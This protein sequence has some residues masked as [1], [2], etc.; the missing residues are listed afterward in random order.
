MDVKQLESFVCVAR[1]GSMTSAA[2]TLYLSAPAL[3]QH[4]NQ[5]EKEAK[6]SLFQR[7]PRGMK[8]TPAGE[9]FYE[10]AL[11]VLELTNSML[12]RCR[13][14]EKSAAQTVRIGS[15]KGLVPDFFPVIQRAVRKY[16]PDIQVEHVEDHF[17][18]LRRMLL[19]GQ[20]DALEFYDAPLTRHPQ[21]QYIPLI[22]EGRYCLMTHDHRLA[23]KAKVTMEDLIGENVYVY[24]F[25]RVPGLR[26]YAA[27]HCPQLT[28]KSSAR[29][30][31]KYESG[32]YATL[33]LCEQGGVCL[34]TPHCAPFFAPLVSVPLEM[35][36]TWSGGLVCPRRMRGPMSRVL[37]ATRREYGLPDQG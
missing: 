24:E 8:L 23:K 30:E 37:E 26:E 6:V 13:E 11:K 18:E 36:M 4:I 20:I 14:M 17:E 19:N 3:A 28:I 2:Q 33:D 10:D 32:Y 31:V 27:T 9:I 12:L 15:L 25:E 22:V 7:S 16:C 35:E 29:G 1:M 21:L 5:L 34:I